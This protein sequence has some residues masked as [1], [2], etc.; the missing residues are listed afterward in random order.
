MQDTNKTYRLDAPE[1][2]TKVGGGKR[3]PVGI[4]TKVK[5][6]E[7]EFSEK[8]GY[9]DIEFTNDKGETAQKRLWK[10]EGKFPAEGKSVAEAID[11]E[12]YANLSVIRILVEATLSESSITNFNGTYEELVK[13]AVAAIKA[14]IP[15]TKGR[16]N[17]KLT[18]DKNGVYAEMG[19][20]GSLEKYVEDTP[21]DL[22]YSTWELDNRMTKKE[23]A[24]AF[25]QKADAQLGNLFSGF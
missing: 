18:Y 13:R 24:K 15:T 20:Y 3:M 11:D 14:A 2:T 16:F 7:I 4:H 25:T 5:L 21:T 23:Q 8:D 9:V 1:I 12:S 19:K 10:P 22:Y 6:S 17:I